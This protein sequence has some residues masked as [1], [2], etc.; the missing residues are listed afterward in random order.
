MD[1]IAPSGLCGWVNSR[2]SLNRIPTNSFPLFFYNHSTFTCLDHTRRHTRRPPTMCRLCFANYVQT[3]ILQHIWTSWVSANQN[4]V[5]L[6]FAETLHWR[7]NMCFLLL[8]TWPSSA[9]ESPVFMMMTMW[10]I[11][12]LTVDSPSTVQQWQTLY[13]VPLCRY[14]R[15]P[16]QFV[17]EL[18]VSFYDTQQLHCNL[19]IVANFTL[20]LTGN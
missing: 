7:G 10:T 11:I 17:D 15:G 6:V 4:S 20:Q 2:K 18:N 19:N 3:A 9:N 12:R 8:V 13:S 16:R 14:L 5:S 1:T